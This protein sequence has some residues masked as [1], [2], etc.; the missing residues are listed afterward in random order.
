MRDRAA[1]AIVAVG[2][3]LASVG[4]HL[5][6]RPMGDTDSYAASAEILSS[7]WRSLPERTPGYPALLLITGATDGTSVVLF[8]VQLAM[9]LITIALV[10]DLAR[11]VRVG[12]GAR[13]VL[14]ALLVA[15]AVMLRVLYAG[16]ESLS[17][18][19]FTLVLWLLLADAPRGHR[20]TPW[21]IGL[22]C[23]AASLVRPTFVLL[24]VPV[25]VIAA[26][27][28]TP[29]AGRRRAVMAIA[30]PAVLVAGSLSLFN[31][32][33]FDSPGLTPL[34]PYHLSSRTSPYVENLPASYEP[35]RSVLIEARDRA[36]L[37]G[38]EFAPGNFIW[39]AREDLARVT[40]KS[41]PELDRYVLEMDLV[42]IT[43]NPFAYLDTVQTASVNYSTMDSQP[44]VLDAGRPAAWV[45]QAF[46][47]V[48]LAGLLAALSVIP[49]LA[50]T[51]TID[52]RR[53]EVI[54][55]T[56]LL[57]LYVGAV[58]VLVETGT[59][60]LRAPT[61]PALALAFVVAVS[62]IR[63]ARRTTRRHGPTGP[64]APD[65]RPIAPQS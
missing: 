34:A 8:V 46:H 38:E 19:L 42:L 3:T 45:Q 39:S 4:W 23:G 10:L 57:S 12:R 30:V 47:L 53:L 35:A 52:S 49:G 2:T 43:Q 5:R 41:G 37:R 9:H 44:A 55:V 13:A 40:G 11:G 65:V 18:L 14:A 50:L 22:T 61:E 17:A 60:R 15:P 48:L 21:L 25:A 36:L 29:K 33:R 63:A 62:S 26:R 27:R 28:A 54:S 20:W 59:A 24:F 64:A 16:S 1:W 58:S 6:T 31:A 32:V 7:G 51:R 56:L